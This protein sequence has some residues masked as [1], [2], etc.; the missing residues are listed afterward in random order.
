MTCRSDRL[1]NVAAGWSGNRQSIPILQTPPIPSIPDIP[2]DSVQRIRVFTDSHDQGAFETDLFPPLLRPCIDIKIR[3]CIRLLFVPSTSKHPR[4]LFI[5][6]RT[7]TRPSSPAL[8]STFLLKFDNSDARCS[9]ILPH[10]AFSRSTRC[11]SRPTPLPF[12]RFKNPTLLEP[13]R[14]SRIH[15]LFNYDRTRGG[16]RINR[17]D[18]AGRQA[19]TL[20]DGSI[21]CLDKRR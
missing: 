8:S 9:P 4:S 18:G 3:R 20:C 13:T 2:N 1:V 10:C 11:S 17:N 14:E 15:S 5:M 7:R 12:C 16:R 21:P 6:V 19:R